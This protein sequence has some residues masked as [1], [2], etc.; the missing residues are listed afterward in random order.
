MKIVS[1]HQTR[2]CIVQ[3]IYSWEMLGNSFS[4]I[5]EEIIF[6]MS[7]QNIDIKYF[8]DVIFGVFKHKL[9][10]DKIINSYVFIYYIGQIEKAI[11]RLAVFE[12]FYRKDI[13]YKVSIDEAIR[14]TKFFCSEKSYK[15]VNGVL[16]KVF[17]L[18]KKGEKI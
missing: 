11:L 6:E 4:K 14:I 8:Y 9:F 7:Y 10:L 2:I 1:R 13:P 3:A 15:F 16:D 5:N 12:F 17:S 18:I